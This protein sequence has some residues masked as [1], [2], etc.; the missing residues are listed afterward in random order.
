MII[1]GAEEWWSY[2]GLCDGYYEK[3]V[4]PY[5][6][7]DSIWVINDLGISC[8][9]CYLFGYFLGKEIIETSKKE[10]KSRDKGRL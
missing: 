4:D 1:I 10:G 7:I 6:I 8:Q 5:E 3:D 9:E 2:V